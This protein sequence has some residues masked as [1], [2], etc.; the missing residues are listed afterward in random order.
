[1]VLSF[2]KKVQLMRKANWFV[3]S[4]S[5][6]LRS[7][8]VFYTIPIATIS[9]GAEQGLTSR[10]W[11]E[12]FATPGARLELNEAGLTRGLQGGIGVANYRI[13]VVGFRALERVDLWIWRV[14]KEPAIVSSELHVN[15][16]EL[17]CGEISPATAELTVNCIGAERKAEI[18]IRSG[19]AEPVGFALL[20]RDGTTKAFAK[21]VPFPFEISSGPCHMSIE[22]EDAGGTLFVA[23]ASGLRPSEKLDVLFTSENE[24]TTLSRRADSLGEWRTMVSPAV[25]DKNSGAGS[26]H[27]K[28]QSCELQLD[29]R[30]GTATAPN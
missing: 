23:K 21:T 7:L 27:L 5:I 30:W 2:E 16:G 29:Y 20:S 11:G 3:S 12:K 26:I 8:V 19:Q 25:R 10:N 17:S 22:R 28:A 15:D 18:S 14:G 4:S 9:S 13:G 24:K 1:L 6:L